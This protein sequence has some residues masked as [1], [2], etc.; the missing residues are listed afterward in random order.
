MNECY[1]YWMEVGLE[2][3]IQ[4]FFS[5]LA[6]ICLGSPDKRKRYAFD[7]L[8]WRSTKGIGVQIWKEDASS[9]IGLLR[10]VYLPSQGVSD[11]M[12]LHEENDMASISFAKFLEMFE[13]LM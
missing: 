3:W 7:A 1:Q 9:Y 6:P 11:M 2:E 10:A 4:V 12:E 8:M 13:E 5:V